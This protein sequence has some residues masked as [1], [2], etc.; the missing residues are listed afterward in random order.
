MKTCNEEGSLS[1]S[2]S[3]SAELFGQKEAECRAEGL[4]AWGVI[5]LVVGVPSGTLEIAL[6][7]L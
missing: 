3:I 5:L 4:R 2:T 6:T 1:N 7:I